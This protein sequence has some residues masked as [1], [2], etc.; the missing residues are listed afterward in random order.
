MKDIEIAKETMFKEELNFVL[1]HKGEVLLTSKKRGIAPIY[2]LYNNT[3]QTFAGAS[4]SDRVIGQAAATLLIDVKIAKVFGELVSEKAIVLLEA[5]NIEVSY[6][7][8]VKNILNRSQDDL[9]PMEKLSLDS[10]RADELNEKI[11][12]FLEDK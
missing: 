6:D 7:K 2:D 12:Q 1:V 5:N 9:C 3:S 11:R 10:P 4:I 8:K